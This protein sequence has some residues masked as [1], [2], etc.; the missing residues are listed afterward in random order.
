[1]PHYSVIAVPPLGGLLAERKEG[2]QPY[3][4]VTLGAALSV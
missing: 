3:A 1:M 4:H 2:R